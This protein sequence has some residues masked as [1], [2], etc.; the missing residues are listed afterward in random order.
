MAHGDRRTTGRRH[1]R[2]GRAIVAALVVMIVFTAAAM[3]FWWDIAWVP[4]VLAAVLFVVILMLAELDRRVQHER[5]LKTGSEEKRERVVRTRTWA[6][7]TK[8][9]LVIVGGLLAIALVV[10]S[11]F[12]EWRAVGIGALL[13]FAWMILIGLPVWLATVKDEEEIEHERLTGE[14][15]PSSHGDR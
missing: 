13:L 7:G 9:T 15:A 6:I 12:L 8:T 5:P 14:P 3:G 1:P 11:I 10:A 2:R 4:A